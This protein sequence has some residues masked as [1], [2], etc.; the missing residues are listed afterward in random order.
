MTIEDL[1]QRYQAQLDAAAISRVQAVFDGAM[2]YD[3][4]TD[5]EYAVYEVECDRLIG[6]P[7]EA[8]E[9]FFAQRRR[10]GGGVGYDESGNLVRGAPGGGTEIIE[11][12]TESS[13]SD[14]RSVVKG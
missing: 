13:A 14:F 4:L 10:E 6:E 1:T 2:S 5:A 3:E 8:E 12:A 7:S 9:A 11:P